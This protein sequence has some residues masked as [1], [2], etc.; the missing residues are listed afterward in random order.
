MKMFKINNVCR[1]CES[2]DL[3]KVLDLGDQPAANSFLNKEEL[4]GDEPKFPL[5]VYFC[6]NCN[7][8]QLIHI[9]DPTV[10][11]RSY[12]YLSSGMPKVS[13]YWQAYAQQ[14]ITDYLPEKNRFIVEFGSN[15]GILLKFFKDS[16]YKVLGVDPAENVAKI[17]EERGIPMVV[18]FFG[19]SIASEI[20]KNHG[21]AEVI[22]ANNVLAHIDDHQD[23]CRGIKML[24]APRGVWA[25][26]A[27]YLIDMFENLTYDTIYHEHL[28]FLSIR[29]LQKLF[30]RYGLEIFNAKVVQAQGQS[31]RLFVGHSGAHLVSE[32]VFE[33]IGREL[34]Y[35]LDSG[36]S[37]FDLARRVE[38]SRS[39]LVSLLRGLKSKGKTIA[40]YGAPAKGNTLLNYCRIGTDILDY[41]LEDLPTKQG[42]YTPGRHIPVVDREWACLNPPDYYLMLA[43]NY[44]GAILEKETDYIRK[45]GKFII[46]IGDE[47]KII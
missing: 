10:L 13:P 19:E 15:D 33:L 39:I 17:A 5:E 4:K 41:A 46:P 27:P 8:A 3:V 28:S 1:D 6:G 47:P 25:I 45:G 26:E 36:R 14:V 44:K 20:V 34:E 37:Y 16:G 38:K 23:I 7:L 18:D 21:R 31:L 40:A 32:T 11:F 24:L 12:I 22:I 42:L 2:S 35:C 9:V 43:W 30:A 29:P